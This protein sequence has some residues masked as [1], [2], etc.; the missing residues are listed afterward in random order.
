MIHVPGSNSINLALH[1]NG[2]RFREHSRA[3]LSFMKDVSRHDAKKVGSESALS[4]VRWNRNLYVLKI[5]NIDSIIYITLTL[6]AESPQLLE[7]FFY[8]A[9]NTTLNKNL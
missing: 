4:K 3:C 2:T 1:V 6:G 9:T 7:R 8:L 5:R